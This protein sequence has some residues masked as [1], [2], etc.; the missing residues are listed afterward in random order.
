MKRRTILH[1]SAMSLVGGLAGCLGD[2][3]ETPESAAD[4]TDETSES[5]TSGADD[6][7]DGE[8]DDADETT[9]DD[10]EAADEP[11]GG[12]VVTEEDPETL[13]DHETFERYQDP[14]ATHVEG[15]RYAVAVKAIQYAYIPGSVEPITV[16]EN[17]EVT[18]YV[19]SLDATHAFTIEDKNVNVEVAQGKILET[20]VSFGDY[21]EP[22]TYEITC[23]D[24]FCTESEQREHMIGEI[25]VQPDGEGSE[26][27]S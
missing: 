27:G 11:A 24:E 17:S 3:D 8:R 1:V 5:G 12:E 26:T 23:G 14:D 13:T 20:T 2:D 6:A 15:D 9:E 22:T 21:D 10:T 7:S 25:I 19:G 4:G 16:P 18:F